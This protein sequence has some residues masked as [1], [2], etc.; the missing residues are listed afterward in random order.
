MYRL[1]G[2]LTT[3]KA[4]VS[5]PLRIGQK[6]RINNVGAHGLSDLAHGFADGIEKGSAGILHE[7][8]SVRNLFRMWQY[9]G[10]GF[11]VSTTTVPCHDRDGRMVR[12]PGSGSIKGSI[13]QQSYRPSPLKSQII[14][15]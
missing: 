8:P 3:D 7:V 1:V 12:Q 5:Q 6:L 10:N 14:V 4:L 15:P 9:P 11:A 13:W 2:L